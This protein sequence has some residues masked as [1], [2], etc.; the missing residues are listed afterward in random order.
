MT[1]TRLLPPIIVKLLR[2]EVDVNSDWVALADLGRE[3]YRD[4][5]AGRAYVPIEAPGFSDHI[6]AALERFLLACWKQGWAE[7]GEVGR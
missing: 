5:K 6:V 1:T 4:G 3:R 2:G 7:A